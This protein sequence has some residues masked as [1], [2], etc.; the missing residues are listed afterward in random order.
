M[1]LFGSNADRTARAVLSDEQ[2][3]HLAHTIIPVYLRVMAE[4]AETAADHGD[5]RL[6]A[7]FRRQADEANEMMEALDAMETV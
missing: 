3:S 2:I 7:Q 4:D 6:A 5:E 1:P